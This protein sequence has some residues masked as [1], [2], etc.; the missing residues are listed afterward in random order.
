MIAFI[1]GTAAD[2][3]DGCLIIENNGIG[4]RIL[5]PA[6]LSDRVRRGDDVMVY[7]HLGVREDALTLYGFATRDDLS[8]F[9]LLLG[10]SGIGPK[11]AL[12]VLSVMSA[13]DLRFAVLAEDLRTL[14]K[15]PG[16]GRKTAQ[17]LV[18]ELKDKID[19]RDA[20]VIG[21]SSAAGTA[22]PTADEAAQSEAVMALTALGYPS[23]EAYK[24]VRTAAALKPD[25]AVEDLLKTALKQL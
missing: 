17:K 24:A 10:V 18:L 3:S 6:R 8:L 21:D 1:K 9:R 12:S 7:T 4:Y 14:S 23:A 19:I 25:A 20:A 22:V 13:E 16:I 15:I 5:V 2:A 11:G